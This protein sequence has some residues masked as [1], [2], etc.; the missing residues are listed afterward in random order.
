MI[1]DPNCWVEL[2][3]ASPDGPRTTPLVFVGT[4]SPVGPVPPNPAPAQPH[5]EGDIFVS[6]NGYGSSV[7]DAGTSSWQSLGQASQS[8]THGGEVYWGYG[9]TVQ[10][11]PAWPAPVE[12]EARFN[13]D[14]IEVLTSGVWTPQL[15]APGSEYVDVATG[16]VYAINDDGS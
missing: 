4:G 7:W 2:Q 8:Q 11:D 15:T 10:R 13:V 6:S 12:G 3:G 14:V 5:V 16:T 1:I 9:T